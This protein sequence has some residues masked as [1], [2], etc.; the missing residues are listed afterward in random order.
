MKQEKLQ[1]INRCP[2]GDDDDDDPE[3]EPGSIEP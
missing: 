1:Q 3:P 2:G